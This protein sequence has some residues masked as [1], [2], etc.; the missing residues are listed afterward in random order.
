MKKTTRFCSLVLLLFSMIASNHWGTLLKNVD[1]HPPPPDKQAYRLHYQGSLLYAEGK[2]RQ[3]SGHFE[4]AY[5]LFPENFSFAL[6]HGLCLG[7]MGEPGTAKNVLEKARRLVASNDQERQQKLALAT[8]FLGM[9]YSYADRYGEALPF[10]R[11]AIAM[12]QNI[13]QK[14]LLSIFYNALGKAILLNQGRN[15][16]RRNYQ[17]LHYHVHRR[18]MEKAFAAFESAVKADPENTIALYNY[19]LLAD[20]LKVTSIL[21]EADSTQPQRKEYKPTFINMHSTIISDL[22]LNNYDELVFLVD[23]SGSMVM[24]KVV[25]YGADR[26]TAM[27][28]LCLKILPEIDT[29]IA[30]G[31]GTIGGVCDS[32]PDLWFASGGI[33]RVDLRSK[34][35][36]LIPD[37]TTPLLTMLLRCPE[38]FSDDPRHS[39]SIFLISDG[40]NTCREG[41]M[42]ICEWATTLAQK[43]IAVNVLTFLSTTSD[44]T[45]A[46]AEYLCLAENT[47]ANIIY[48]D[49]YRCRLEPFAFDIVKTC[50]S[51]IPAME[52]STC[53]GPSV[54]GLWNVWVAE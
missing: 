42:D 6:A 13:A 2:Y 27:K 30:L 20:T 5:Q 9:S 32:P 46:F 31:I 26:F 53:L 4:R 11:D 35:R 8:F 37:G 45:D 14:S 23:I 36:F 19:R 49:N 44:N 54:K 43:G 41:G 24:E 34:L 39:K 10:I 21:P 16:H 7:R 40:A 17:A 28:D 33:S 22:K 15:A 25:C 52:K 29:S 48:L 1:A 47:K 3:A 12:Q 18:D 38:L 50:Q 51:K